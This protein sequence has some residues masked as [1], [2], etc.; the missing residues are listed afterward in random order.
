M[1]VVRDWWHISWRMR[2]CTDSIFERL[3]RHVFATDSYGFRD[4]HIVQT[5]IHIRHVPTLRNWLIYIVRD[6]YIFRDSVYFATYGTLDRLSWQILALRN[7]L[8]YSSYLIHTAWLICVYFVAYGTLERHSWHVLALRNWLMYSSWLTHTAWLVYTSWHT[9]VLT[10]FRD[11]NSPKF[12]HIREPWYIGCDYYMNGN[13]FI[14]V[15]TA[16]ST[17]SGDTYSPCASLKMFFLRSTIDKEPSVFH[18]PM[19]PV[20]C[21]PNY[22]SHVYPYGKCRNIYLHLSWFHESRRAVEWI[23]THEPIVC[24]HGKYVHVE[25][26]V[27]LFHKP[28]SL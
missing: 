6:S 28:M 16:P 13:L 27:S 19:S 18:E 1:Y 2:T 20:E 4:W 7:S 23:V 3:W 26:H 25:S 14:N 12:N 17:D 15:L 9:A 22:Q 24:I 10:D 21:I 5:P 8:I 11:T